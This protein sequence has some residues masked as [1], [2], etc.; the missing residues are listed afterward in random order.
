MTGN[1]IAPLASL[2]A[3]MG[4]RI[5]YR[6]TGAHRPWLVLIHGWCGSADQWTPIVPDLCRDWRVLTLSLPGFGGMSPPP[7]AG[8]TMAAM[9]AAVAALLDGLAIEDAL[10]VGHSMGGPIMTETAICAPDRVK[11][12]LGLD[13]LTDRGYYGRVAPAEIKRRR[14]LFESDYPGR[15]RIMIDDI[16]HPSTGEATRRAIVD[17]MLASAPRDYALD[18]KERLF[19]W[20]AQERWPLVRHPALLLNSSWVARLADPRPMDCFRE[21]EV[22]EYDSGHFPMMESPGMIVEKLRPCLDRLVYASSLD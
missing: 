16:A 1:V 3:P 14:Q 22:V 11:A 8:M 5:G 13:T 17:G 21:T 7:P 15:M 6:V 20:D 2:P 12:L 18:V 4:G 19:A 10:L 9:G